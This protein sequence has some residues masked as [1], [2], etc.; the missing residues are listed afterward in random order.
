MITLK[1]YCDSQ[2]RSGVIIYSDVNGNSIFKSNPLATSTNNG[3]EFTYTIEK[4]AMHSIWVATAVVL[5]A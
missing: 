4:I 3:S 5:L 2:N 1:G